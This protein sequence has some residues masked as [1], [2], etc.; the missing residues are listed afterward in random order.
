MTSAILEGNPTSASRY[1]PLVNPELDR[2][3][4][5]ALSRNPPERPTVREFI[6]SLRAL[7]S[8]YPFE[9]RPGTLS[10]KGARIYDAPA[11][12]QPWLWV[13]LLA[14]AFVM[15]LLLFLPGFGANP[16]GALAPAT[17]TP[18]RA[19]TVTPAATVE[20]GAPAERAAAP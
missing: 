1:E 12:R 4:S 14:I 7:Q 5:W 6:L 9:F 18:T 10:R 19:V 11:V 20:A 13:A 2:L 15:G 3:I 17:V 16:A 8:K